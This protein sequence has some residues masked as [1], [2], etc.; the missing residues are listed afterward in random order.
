M[1]SQAKIN[2]RKARWRAFLRCEG[3][4]FLFLV[5][6]PGEPER[7]FRGCGPATKA[8]RL[9]VREAVGAV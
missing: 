5:R 9:L 1:N 8:S 3:P 2:E 4:G 6:A 7:K